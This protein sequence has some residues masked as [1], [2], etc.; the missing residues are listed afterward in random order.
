MMHFSCD[1]CGKSLQPGDD[2]RYVVKIEAY[3]AQ[4]PMEITEEDLDQDHMEAVSE[5]LRDVEDGLEDGE[6]DP[7][8]QN[9]RFDLCPDCHQ[10][11]VR[12]P[13]GKENTHKLFF[14]KN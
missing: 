14:S 5:L 9:F 4:D 13:L 10:R 2:D 1:L 3:A 6:V 7:A 12:D 11:F 8:C